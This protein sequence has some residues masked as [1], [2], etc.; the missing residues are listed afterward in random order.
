LSFVLLLFILSLTLI[1]IRLLRR[2]T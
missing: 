1:E 2:R